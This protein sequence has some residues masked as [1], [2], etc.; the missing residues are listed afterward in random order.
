MLCSSPPVVQDQYS[1]LLSAH[2]FIQ[3][4]PST[5]E[6]K[7]WF[8][9][10]GELWITDFFGSLPGDQLIDLVQDVPLVLMFDMCIFW[11]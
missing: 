7:V 6:D 3:S 10:T 4:A 9:G 5:L 11:V 1:V 2:Q 8:Y